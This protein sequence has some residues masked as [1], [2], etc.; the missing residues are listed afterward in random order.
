MITKRSL[1]ALLLMFLPGAAGSGQPMT[2]TSLLH[3]TGS[4]ERPEQP[5][6]S[7]LTYN[8]KGL[9]WPVARGR[10]A[11]LEAIALRLRLLRAQA[12]QPHIVV[13]QEAFTE[14]ARSIGQTAGYPYIVDGP[15]ASFPNPATPTVQDRRFMAS[16]RW[17]KGETQGKW[18]GSGLQVLSDYPVVGVRRIAY[19]A[20]A[21]AGYDCL[22]NKGAL[23]VSVKI[24]GAPTPVD[25]I[26]THLYSK[27]SSGVPDER[28]LY[29][30]RR[31]LG[32]LTAFIR[33]SRDPRRPLIV[34]GDFNVGA[35]R[36]RRAA[37][38]GRT[39]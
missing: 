21:C 8:V 28:S 5:I 20:F 2:L 13:L 34:A 27:R 24:P 1:A 30:Y 35:A 17:W 9:P 11:A 14:K 36:P 26:T 23:L 4:L 25:I 10:D 18:V 38:L 19:P 16:A 22:A 7:V 39:G 6:I 29:A 3:P 32:V 15:T 33:D 37:R 12:R 31:Q